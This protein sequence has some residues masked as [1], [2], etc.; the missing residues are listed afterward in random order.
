VSKRFLK[1][2]KNLFLVE[3]FIPK[4]K[5]INLKQDKTNHIWIYDRSWSMNY[6]LPKLCEDLINKAK[7]IPKGDTISLSW[8][9]GEGD[10]NFIL[11]GFKITDDSDYSIIEKA[12]RNNSCP[13]SCTCFS[14]ILHDTKTVI[15]DLSI[16]SDRFSLM[17]FTDGVPVVRNYSKEIESIFEAIKS[18][19][20]KITSSIMIGYGNYYNKELMME[21][22]KNFGGQ[23]IHSNNIPE[24][25]IALSDL[26]KNSSDSDKKI[27]IKLDQNPELIFSINDKT[28]NLYNINDKN[29]LKFIPSK[30]SKDYIFY[31]TNKLD[32][33]EKE[34]IL[35]DYTV[36]SGDSKLEDMTKGIYAAAYVLTQKTKTDIALET[37]GILGDKYL[38]DLVNNA[39]TNQEYGNA[40]NEIKTAMSAPSKRFKTGRDITYLPPA[41]AF[42]LLDVIDILMKDDKA[43]FYPYHK[44][45]KYK[46][47]G[48]PTITKGDYPKFEADENVKC[49]FSSLSWNQKK[50][51]LSVLAFIN[52]H[53]KLKGDYKKLGFASEYPTYVYRN[54]ALV[55]D[56]FLNTNTIPV[57]ISE[58]TFNK[59]NDKGLIDNYNE[60]YQEDYIYN[61]YLDRIPVMNRAIAEGKT[62]ATELSKKVF[63]EIELKGKIKALKF[64]RD[65]FAEQGEVKDDVFK[66][67]SDEQIKYLE[68][69][70]I[71]KNGFNPPSETVKA[72]DYYY[73]KE[74]DIK[75]SKYSSLPKVDDIMIK[76][77][78]GKNL[79]P[80]GELIKSGIEI[81]NNSPVSGN[82]V[83]DKIKVAWLDEKLSKIKKELITIRTD[84]QKTKFAIILGKKW[85]DEFD[86]RENCY[87]DVNGKTFTFD[88][89]EKKVLI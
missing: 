81:F 18:I 26:I 3:K 37:L 88:I 20:G 24:F 89:K 17:L 42:C 5:K 12:V 77:N 57:S 61:L 64:L 54:Y 13:I 79:N 1:I 51:N 62:N 74:F 15:N 4:E 86:S 16:F 84:I 71:T 56:G 44:D 68:D 19:E 52:G 87:L 22:A 41:D 48:L 49:N 55:K 80:T 46:R 28:I 31:L 6:E 39:Y 82:K 7:E 45:F 67:L 75:V 60:T 40:E 63:Q 34:V 43:C 36:M 33:D 58:E 76:I 9:S 35:K 25:N 14:E 2:K 66:G 8:F 59:L 50:L 11:K 78:N 53:I 65:K 47:I 72:E 38:I 29:E 30:R 23:L 27:N 32:G 21:M 73:V 85:F 83:S 10:Y 70:G 69:N